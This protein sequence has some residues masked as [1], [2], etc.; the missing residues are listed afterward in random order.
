MKKYIFFDIDGTLT[1]ANPGGIILPST[2]VT[3]RKLKENGHFVAIATG[4]SYSMAKEAMS[5]ADIHNAVCCG[6]NG[7]VIDDQVFYIDPL[8]KEKALEVIQECVEKNIPLGIKKDDTTKIYTHRKDFVEKCPEVKSFAQIVYMDN[9]DYSQF[10]DIHKIHIALKKGTPN[11]LETLKTTGLHFARYHDLSIIVEP[12][13]KY[14]GI[15]DMIHHINGKEEDIV[16]FGDGHNDLSMMS[17]APIAIAMGNAI[18]ELK[19]VATFVTKNC[20]DD[21]IEYAC[22]HFHWI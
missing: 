6:G 16:V 14:K 11:P 13:D 15:L 2:H 3:L 19:E 5:E 7:L 10:E 22:Q 18:D 4:R 12:D 8:D 17:Q 21:G 9:D 20:D 1:N